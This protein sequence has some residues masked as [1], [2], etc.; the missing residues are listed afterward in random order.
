MARPWTSHIWHQQHTVLT[1]S[2]TDCSSTCFILLVLGFFLCLVQFKALCFRMVTIWMCFSPTSAWT[3]KPN[4]HLTTL[5]FQLNLFNWKSNSRQNCR[6]FVGIL[7]SPNLGGKDRKHK[8]LSV[9][10]HRPNLREL[11]WISVTIWHALL[12]LSQFLFSL[13]QSAFYVKANVSV[14]ICLGCLY[15]A[16][17]FLSLQIPPLWHFLCSRPQNT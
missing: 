12:N 1:V 3:L 10:C 8:W 4:W 14:W 2:F 5:L 16:I 13:N 15:S 6:C 9:F 7:T 17:W 11:S